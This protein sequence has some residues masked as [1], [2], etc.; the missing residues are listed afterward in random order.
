MSP[1]ARIDDRLYDNQKAEA[2]TANALGHLLLSLSYAGRHTTDGALP[3]HFVR[4]HLRTRRGGKRAVDE[5]VD[6]GWLHRAG[7]LCDRCLAALRTAGANPPAEGFYIHDYLDHNHSRAQIESRRKSDRSRQAG[8]RE[9]ERQA[10]IPWQSTDDV[11]RR[12][13]HAPAL[14][15]RRGSG[16][17]A[18]NEPLSLDAGAGGETLGA[19]HQHQ[20]GEVVA[21]LETAPRFAGKAQLADFAVEQAIANHLDKDPVRAARDAVIASADDEFRMQAPASVFR[22]MLERQKPPGGSAGA[23]KRFAAE[24]DD[25]SAYEALEESA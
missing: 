20:V 6:R 19:Q 1:Y 17:Q 22:L 4:R 9:R 12:E 5:L 8:H 14:P 10:V 24:R 18:A 21:I 2:T 7:E 11:S 13:S 16:E 25:R 23:G 3:E 15:D